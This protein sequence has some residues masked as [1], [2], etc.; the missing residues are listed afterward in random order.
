[1]WKPEGHADCLPVLEDPCFKFTSTRNNNQDSPVSRRCAWNHVFD[2]VSVSWGISD[3]TKLTF[4][5]QFIQDPDHLEGALSHLSRLLKFFDGSFVNP[6]IFLGQMA[7]SGRLARIYV[8]SDDHVDRSL[9]L[10]HLGLDLAVV[11]VTPVFWQQTQ[12][13]FPL[14]ISLIPIFLLLTLPCLQ[15]AHWSLALGELTLNSFMTLKPHQE[16]HK[17]L[18]KGSGRNTAPINTHSW[19][20]RSPSIITSASKSSWKGPLIVYNIC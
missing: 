20:S 3:D 16:S 11:F 14:F 5:L 7:S 9:F 10:S 6:T 4:S 2:K 8:S 12:C 13:F 1:M 15:C 19:L 18:L 17:R